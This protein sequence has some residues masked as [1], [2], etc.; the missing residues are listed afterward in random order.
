MWMGVDDTDGKDGGCTTYV[1]S[2][3]LT[4]ARERSIDL[5]GEPRLVRLN[6]NIPFKT[7]GN[8]ALSACFGIGSGPPR[9][10]AMIGGRSV[11]GY[12]AGRPLPRARADEWFEAAWQVVRRLASPEPGTDPAL[13]AAPRRLP[14]ELYYRAVRG[15]VSV[16]S[17]RRVV[18]AAGGRLRTAGT[19]RGIVGAAAAIA[20]PGRRATWERIAYRAP[21]VWGTPRRVDPASVVAAQ[22]ADERLFLCADGRTRRLLV[23]PHTACPI[24]YGLRSTDRRALAT[25]ARRVRSE[26]VDRWVV[27]RTNQGTGDHLSRRS[28]RTLRPFDSARVRGTIVGRPV[29]LRGGHVRFDLTDGSARALT[30][31]VFEP[32]KT[33]PTLAAGLEDGDPLELWGGRAAD[34]E[35]RVEGIR[36]L[37]PLDRGQSRPPWC[38]ACTR[39]TDSLGRGRGFRCGRCRR[40]WPPEAALQVP[41]SSRFGPGTYHPT[42]SARRHLAPRGPECPPAGLDL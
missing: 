4:A 3:L 2:E 29:P 26:P 6:P 11:R 33:L 7:R 31:L 35:L 21:S 39:S 32:T 27:F 8:G 18:R 16:A 22:R 17:A 40:R 14:A 38:P 25:A 36:I 37:R 1:L 23:A 13:V 5:L 9:R 30:C 41:A 42:P 34:P 28:I 12:P 10:V 20:W 24:L 19:E 15:R